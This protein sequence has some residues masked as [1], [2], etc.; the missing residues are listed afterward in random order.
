MCRNNLI[1]F[2][3]KNKLKILLL[4]DISS[5]TTENIRPTFHMLRLALSFNIYSLLQ[6]IAKWH[7]CTACVSKNRS[8]AGDINYMKQTIVFTNYFHFANLSNVGHA[9]RCLAQLWICLVMTPNMLI[10]INPTGH[11]NGKLWN[12]NA[13]KIKKYIFSISRSD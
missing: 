11:S 9:F 4:L 3:Y 1:R 12:L 6:P 7:V 2:R 8:T 5:T 10:H 13:E